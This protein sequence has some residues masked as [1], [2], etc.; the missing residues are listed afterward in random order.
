MINPLH[1]SIGYIRETGP[2]RA[3]AAPAPASATDDMSD[4]A[5][6]Q[7]LS[8][9]SSGDSGPGLMSLDQMLAVQASHTPDMPAAI[10]PPRAADPVDQIAGLVLQNREVF[11]RHTPAAIDGW[12]IAG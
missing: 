9:W 8:G 5:L 11:K 6:E 4:A 10:P 12:N 1:N 7:F 3:P 2:V